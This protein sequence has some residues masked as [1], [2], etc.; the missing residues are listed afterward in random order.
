MAR[1]GEDVLSD[2]DKVRI[3]SEFILHAPPGE[4]NEV[5]NDVRV[6]LNNDSLL[7]EEA[8]GSFVQYNKDQFTPCKID[9][10][11][12][13][14]LIT[15]HGDLGG[16]RFLDPRSKQSFRY[17]HLRKESSDL[18]P[19]PASNRA[20]EPWRA[21]LE[22]PFTDYVHNQY[23]QGVCT[24]YGAVADDSGSYITL[25]A[26]VE[27]HQF[28]PKNFW[29]GRWRS[30]WTATFQ[31]G[32]GQAEI[33]GILK[34]QVHYYEDGNVQL[35]TSKEVKESLKVVN[36][37]QLAKDFCRIVSE[38][39][40]DYQTAISENYKT[41]SDTTFKALRRQLPVTRTK[42][43]WNKLLSYKIGSELKTS[44]N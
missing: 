24:V 20:S 15:Q 23:K 11:D 16:G 7:K 4:F 9:G 41:M 18:R 36:E 1:I 21:A 17:D 10:S 6:L 40:N 35:V 28:S 27:S 39:E 30:Q 44:A 38:S 33:V 3:V 43:D 25:T 14:V 42:I 8:S 22:G 29:N 19:A 34:V 2:R 12:E 37:A 31:E 13:Q 5:F 32:G 26:C